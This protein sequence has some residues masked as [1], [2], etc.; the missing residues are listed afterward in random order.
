MALLV[1]DISHCRKSNV[2]ADKVGLL[3]V[4]TRS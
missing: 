4:K 2:V 3:L 1:V